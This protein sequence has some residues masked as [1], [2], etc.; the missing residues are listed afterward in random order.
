MLSFIVMCLG[1]LLMAEMA[2]LTE[3]TA[4]TDRVE[5]FLREVGVAFRLFPHA[6]VFTSAEAARVRGT[7]PEEGAKALL[8]KADD[9]FY[10]VVISGVLRVD[11]KALRRLLGTHGV[12]FA[13]EEELLQITGCRP[14]AVPPLGNL[15]DL[16][17]LMDT[18]LRQC[19]HVSFNAGSNGWSV[20]MRREDLERLTQPRIGAF[21]ADRAREITPG[22]EGG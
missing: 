1:A 13:T 15:F 14:G 6:P 4:V 9:R 19:E 17:V 11:N 3:R 7:T 10:L 5:S 8:V 16:P 2:G 18:S 21:A 22:S 12:R 20:T